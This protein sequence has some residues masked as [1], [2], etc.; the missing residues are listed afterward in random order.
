M[1]DKRSRIKR[2]FYVYYSDKR[3]NHLKRLNFFQLCP[4]FDKN[5]DWNNIS[6]TLTFL[7]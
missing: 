1:Y 5:V 3:V 7:Y 2:E 4:P 6:N